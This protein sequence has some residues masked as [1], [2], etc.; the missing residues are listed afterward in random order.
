MPRAE[1]QWTRGPWEVRTG[2][3]KEG[4]LQGDLKG[5]REESGKSILG[6]ARSVCKG[7]ATREDE[8]G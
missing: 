7:W 1:G 2:F 3:P 4:A 8:A 6:R 5:G